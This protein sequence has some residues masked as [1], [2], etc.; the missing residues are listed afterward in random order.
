MSKMDWRN[1]L[2]ETS[3]KYGTP[4]MSAIPD[5]EIP[6]EDAPIGGVKSF[7]DMSDD[8]LARVYHASSKWKAYCDFSVSIY[9]SAE[10]QFKGELNRARVSAYKRLYSNQGKKPPNVKEGEIMVEADPQ[11]QECSK[12][13]ED[14]QSYHVY[15]DKR[16]SEFTQMAIASGNERKK[17]S[18]REARTGGIFE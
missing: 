9:H 1:S 16:A 11:V 14:M 17:R 3:R 18:E 6:V 15:F 7:T 4:S 12:A 10:I 13:L 5:R 8:E 2:D